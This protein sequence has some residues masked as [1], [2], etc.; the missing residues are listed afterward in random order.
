MDL[1]QLPT[2]FPKRKSYEYS[3]LAHEQRSEQSREEAK[4]F[5]LKHRHSTRWYS[6]PLRGIL[7]LVAGGS[8]LLNIVQFVDWRSGSKAAA[9]GD[10]SM[11]QFGI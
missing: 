2:F 1:F 6:W 8:L 5:S 10:Q 4:P 11:S 9:L 3:L 7:Y